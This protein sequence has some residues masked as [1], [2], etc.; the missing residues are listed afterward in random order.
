MCFKLTLEGNKT[1][2]S[3]HI[4]NF[5]IKLKQFKKKKFEKQNSYLILSPTT[6]SLTGNMERFVNER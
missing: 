1:K 6:I 4:S 2:V 5:R 3:S